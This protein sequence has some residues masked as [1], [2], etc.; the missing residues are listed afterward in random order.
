MDADRGISVRGRLA[1][2]VASAA[3]AACLVAPGVAGADWEQIGGPVAT[4]DQPL[5]GLDLKRIGGTPYAAWSESNGH[6]GVVRVARLTADG[7][8]W[9]PVGGAVNHDANR[10]AE[11]PS[12]AAGPGGVPWIAWAE[13]DRD[14]IKQIRAAHLSSYGDRWIEPDP[15]DWSINT[16]DPAGSPYGGERDKRIFYAS[17]P[18][19]VFLGERPY[20]AFLGNNPTEYEVDVV[21]LAPGGGSWERIV[22]GVGSPIPGAPDAAVVGGLLHVGVTSYFDNVAADRLNA[23]GS[24]DEL[25][26]GFANG[27]AD[28]CGG[29]P[30]GGFNRVAELGGDPFVL[31][32]AH[33]GCEERHVY[34]SH[35]DNGRWRVAGDGPVGVG[36]PG[37]SLR[38]IGGRLY[39]AFAD[40]GD[41]HVSRLADDGAGWIETPGALT[42]T[43]TGAAVLTGI[44][45]VPHVAWSETDGST[46]LLRVARLDGA[47]EP[48]GA[49]DADGSGLGT[50]PNV[51]ATPVLPEL[52]SGRCRTE[53]RGH[54]YSEVLYGTANGDTLRGLGGADSMRGGPGGDCLFGGPGNDW[55]DGGAGVDTLRGGAD[56]DRLA[57]NESEDR[58]YGD[59]GSDQLSGG[60]DDDGL[61]GGGGDDVLRGGR[62]WDTFSAGPG[63]DTIRAADGR[64][65][66]VGCGR[67]FDVARVDRFD[68]PR[69]C[70]RVIVVH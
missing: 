26:G 14:G 29:S 43:A 15:R 17:S 32:S 60:G 36:S 13:L 33:G 9:V 4:S 63:D 68:R 16:R 46:T 5:Q 8:S 39:A 52:V 67:G 37:T 55:L 45:G 1:A 44:D 57:G 54:E 27:S 7:G 25:G 41:L 19:L 28:D 42:A 35:V 6:N 38:E 22:R 30:S 64:G 18:R 49:D 50:D 70:E 61:H 20:I 10:D 23:D 59:A 2:V 56:A 58:L 69:N 66:T 51:N 24:W 65:E 53:V 11:T 34:V 48:I 31:W 62:G 21:R 47:P 12:L 3:V 40:G